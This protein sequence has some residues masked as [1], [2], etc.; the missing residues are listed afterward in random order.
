[1]KW[2]LAPVLCTVTSQT[3]SRPSRVMPNTNGSA[4][5]LEVCVDINVVPFIKCGFVL[6]EPV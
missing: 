1:M 6:A 4:R 3:L 2:I 5:S